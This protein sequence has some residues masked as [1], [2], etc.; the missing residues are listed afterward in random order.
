MFLPVLAVAVAVV[1]LFTACN[2]GLHWTGKA[3]G[4]AHRGR[5]GISGRP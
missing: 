3:A 2:E 4:S 1:L 5:H